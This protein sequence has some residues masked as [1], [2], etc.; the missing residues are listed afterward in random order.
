MQAKQNSFFYH[1]Y[2]IV[3]QWLSAQWEN[4]VVIHW[5]T[6][7]QGGS[8]S[9]LG[10][11]AQWFHDRYCSLFHRL[12]LPRLLAGSIFLHPLL[13]AALAMVLLPLLPT[14]GVMALVCASFFSLALCMGVDRNRT[15]CPS[16]LNGYIL[17][18][19]A[20]YLYATLTSSS[21]RGSLFPGLL[22]ILFVL[23]FF[24]LTSCG[25]QKDAVPKLLGAMVAVGVL[26]SLYG[27]YQALFPSQFRNVWTDT[28]MFSSIV[29]RVYSTLENPNVLGEYFLLVIPLGIGLLMT[30]RSWKTRILWLAACGIMGICLILTYSRGCYLGLLFAVAMFLVLK[31]RR[32]LILGIVAVALCP[33][34]LPETV[35]SRFTS[36][37]DMG[38]TS[39]S[40]RVY[41]WMGTLAMLKDYW[42]CG[43]GPG[44]DAFNKVYP[45]YAYNAITAPHSHN[46][47][48]QITCDTGI[49][50]LAVFLLLMV[51]FY[52]MMFT[53]IRQETDTQLK[54]FQIAGVSAVSGFLLQSMTDYTFYNY[55][56]MLLFWTMLG[57]CVLFARLGQ[58]APAET[59]AVHD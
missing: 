34:Y 51:G 47:Y 11:W 16:P 27:F 32:F 13:F 53:A 7:Q 24:A 38:D 25:I 54:T 17:L 36:I 35:L 43:V 29:F 50:G 2:C 33:L 39:T 59:E 44:T 52:R 28:D 6:H 48:L 56:V 3:R 41:I 22:T 4:S 31:D 23:F 42:F 5:L 12:R 14:M 45:E 19:A 40:Y 18:Y 46:L 58:K 20:V 10:N 57:L 15:L 8:T 30:A 55:R 1:I 21:L 37:G 9:L 26:V 49:A